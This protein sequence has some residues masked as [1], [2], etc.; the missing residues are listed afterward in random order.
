MSYLARRLSLVALSIITMALATPSVA[1]AQSGGQTAAQVK[2][3][4]AVRAVK[5]RKVRHL[6]HETRIACARAANSQ[7]C[8]RDRRLL[9]RAKKSLANVQALF[10]AHSGSAVA[11]TS[12]PVLSVSGT[13]IRWARVATVDRYVLA[14]SVTGKATVYKVIYGLSITPPAQPGVTV[15][16]A[17]R[18]DVAGSAWAREVSIAYPATT[19]TPTPTPSPTPSPTSA[20]TLS[21]SGNTINW[22]RVATVDRYLLA[23][24]QTGK[25]TV[26]SV[27]YGL[28]ITPP[29]VPGE[30]VRYG[31]R[32]DVAGSA[33][34]GE[35]SIAYPATTPTPTPTPSPTP[36]PTPSPTPTPTPTPAPA[37]FESGIVSGSD[38]MGEVPVAGRL[39]AKVVRVEFGIAQ[40]ASALRP[41]IGAYAA[42]GVR[43]VPLAGFHASMPTVDEARNLAN[44]AREFGPGGT[45]WSGRADGLMAIHEIEFGNETSYGY[46]YG[47]NWDS[48]SYLARAKT[49]ALRLKDA[50]IAIQ[51]VNPSVGLL[52]QID[53]ANTGSQNWISG[54][55]SAVPDIGSRVSGWSIHPY[56]QRSTWETRMDHVIAWSAARGAPATIPLWITEWGLS[57]DNGRCLTDNYTWDKCM[58]YATAGTTLTTTVRDMR[59]KYGSRLHA[60]ILYSG[61]DLRATGTSTE[62][63]SYFGALR[64]DMSDKGAYSVAVRALLASK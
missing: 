31:L 32:T 34:A 36:V 11:P 14:T 52:G 58:T 12:A 8:R 64:Q 18:T 60:V 53:D 30:T 35:V 41:V 3:L 56:G 15:R 46:Q 24:S 37:S 42:N 50:Q 45:F 17:L 4:D 26:Y 5:Q 51:A 21:V 22:A 19:P 55:F 27:I 61:R 63:E 28:S 25:A 29:A 43:V 7:T 38:V 62:R 54:V 44:W 20:P 16:Y 9:R 33:W 1:P 39:G 49:Y 13:T 48:A 47:D 6:R 57:T 40:P 10:V 59:A 23:T 2:S